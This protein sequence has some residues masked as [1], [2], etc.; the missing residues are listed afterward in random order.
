[1]TVVSATGPVIV[2]EYRDASYVSEVVSFFAFVTVSGCPTAL[3]VITV[4]CA[5][6]P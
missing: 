3:Y 2:W 6:G 4:S 5:D 1:M